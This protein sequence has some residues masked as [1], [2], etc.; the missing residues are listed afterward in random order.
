MQNFFIF[1]YFINTYISFRQNFL[2]V[3]SFFQ[4]QDKQPKVW[5]F[6]N[7]VY[8]PKNLRTQLE[9]RVWLEPRMAGQRPPVGCS[10]DGRGGSLAILS[11]AILPPSQS[12]TV[13]CGLLGQLKL[14]EKSANGGKIDQLIK[15]C[16]IKQV[17]DSRKILYQTYF[18]CFLRTIY[19][20]VF[21]GEVSESV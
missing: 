13:R 6:L 1:K 8:V 19:S 20:S 9:R 17:S 14:S 18:Q 4:Q 2:L 15:R 21:V 3:N 16:M 7:C 10:E 11:R 12:S 5:H